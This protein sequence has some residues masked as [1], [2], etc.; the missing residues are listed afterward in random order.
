MAL[1][2]EKAA[3][4]LPSAAINCGLIILVS[5]S[6]QLPL[7]MWL[8]TLVSNR[9]RGAVT[10]RLIFFMPYVLADVAAQWVMEPTDQP[11]GNRSA[12]LRD[13]DGN[14]IN[15]FTPLPPRGCARRGSC[16]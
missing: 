3:E 7:A 1:T 13:P 8:A 5:L 2:L 11:W 15:L 10:F 6:I 14:L 4:S 12:L 16:P 9:I